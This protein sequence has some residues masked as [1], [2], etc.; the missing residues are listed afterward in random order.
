[1][2]FGKYSRRLSEKNE[3]FMKRVFLDPFAK[4]KGD[5]KRYGREKSHPTENHYG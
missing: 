2:I 5:A 1:M 4:S 3:G